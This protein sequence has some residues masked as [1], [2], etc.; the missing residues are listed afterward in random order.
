M[1][2]VILCL[3]AII[4]TG[5][6]IGVCA[7]G[8][9]KSRNEKKY[10]PDKLEIEFERDRGKIVRYL[11]EGG[12]AKGLA[13]NRINLIE[14]LEINNINRFKHLINSLKR[15]KIVTAGPQSVK[16]T[17]FGQQYCDFIERKSNYGSKTSS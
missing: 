1:L 13:I 9:Y 16:L 11:S 8:L 14:D 7:I 10:G 3:V 17:K 15:D 6:L 5:W 2:V 4:G 12:I